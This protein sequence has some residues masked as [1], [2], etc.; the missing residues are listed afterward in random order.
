MYHFSLYS[1][2]QAA[3]GELYTVDLVQPWWRFGSEGPPVRKDST[4]WFPFLCLHSDHLKYASISVS[5]SQ[6]LRFCISCFLNHL[7]LEDRMW[8][9]WKRVAKEV[10]VIV[11][12]FPI[13]SQ[14]EQFSSTLEPEHLNVL[15][16][17]L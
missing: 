7:C 4:G 9:T 5:E 6:I 17:E 14:G 1:A 16:T 12:A 15:E 8:E 10:G 13:L 3:V 11:A 2:G